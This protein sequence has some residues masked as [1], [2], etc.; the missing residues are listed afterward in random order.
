MLKFLKIKVIFY[1][2]CDTIFLLG[3]T[4]IPIVVIAWGISS[5]NNNYKVCEVTTD[6]NIK[7]IRVDDLDQNFIKKFNFDIIS[8]LSSDEE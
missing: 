1:S 6:T 4:I 8:T 3:L 2:V 5:I 7:V